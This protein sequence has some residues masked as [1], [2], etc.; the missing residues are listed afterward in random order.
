MSQANSIKLTAPAKINLF[1]HVV[2]KRGDGF[3]LLQS[4]TS[5]ANFGDEIT[6]SPSNEFKFSFDSTTEN[7]PTDESNLIVCTANLLGSTLN[8]NLNCHIHLKK[9][10]PIGAGLGGGSSDAAATIRGLFEFWN[11]TLPQNELDNILL[12]LGAD[13]PAC[14]HGKACYFEGIGEII[15]PAQS[16]PPLHA[17]LIYPNKH[18]ATKDIFK[19]YNSDFSKEIVLPQHFENK[20]NVTEFLSKQ[21]NDLTEAAIQN[22]PDIKNIL[23]ALDK[24]QDCQLS[25]MSGS[26]SACFGIFDTKEQVQKTANTIKKENPDWWIQPVMIQ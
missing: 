10:I 25:R 15:T 3:H 26:G 13:V 20:K 14:Y 24:Q 23:D 6:I 1:L 22:I 21:K 18:C 8:K 2:G 11:T 7:F 19:K 9:N 5:F 17:L 16:L 4:L 12:D